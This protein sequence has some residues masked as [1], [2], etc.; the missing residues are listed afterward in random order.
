MGRDKRAHSILTDYLAALGVPYTDG[1]AAEQFAAM[2]FQTL[3]G[4]TKLL[5][6][7]GVKSEGYHLEDK[8][9]IQ[10]ITPPFIA[11]T[12]RGLVIVTA[13]GP[14][15]I[16]YLTQGVAESVAAD[17]FM[18]VWSGDVLISTP[19]AGAKEPD[20]AAHARLQFFMRAK[21]WVML[22]CGIFLLVYLFIANGLWQQ[23]SAYFIAAVDL[24]GLYFTYLL[25]QKSM[26]I[27]NAAADRVCGVLQAGGCDDILDMSASKF[28]GLFGWSEVGF[29][30]FSVSLI[31]M[32][33]LPAMLPWL[34]LCNVCCLP[35]TVWSIWYQRFRA[36]K[37]CTLCV[38]VQSCLWLLFFSYLAGGWLKEAW[39]PTWNF[40]ALG[41]AYLGVMLGING[42]MSLRK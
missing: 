21:R 24:A 37:W 14:E 41:A 34:A 38:S 28:F 3:F 31:T 39:P 17:E 15:K 20:Y 5:E 35:F 22:A 9:E 29:S 19:S 30:Y 36:H 4:L 1:Y 25:V 33:L 6:K 8:S 7:Y 26:H 42:V 11:R 16:D 40:V 13:A 2:P 32:L 18:A 23:V 12:P 10:K 27:H